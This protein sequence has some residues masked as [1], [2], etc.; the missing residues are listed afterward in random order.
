MSATIIE[1]C[2]KALGKTYET[3]LSQSF[4]SS[5]EPWKT[6]HD[7]DEF[8]L[9]IEDGL[10]L[11]FHETTRKLESIFITLVKT[12]PSTV[13]YKGELPKPFASK[14]RQTEV[15]T[16]FGESMTSKGPVKMPLPMGMTGGWDSY[17]LDP[18]THPNIKVVF[19]YTAELTVST[20]IFSLI[21]KGHD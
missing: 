8:S 20:L 21:D 15:R 18:I 2:I 13:V 16:N 6:F 5:A 17:R 14:M 7:D 9:K 11:T 1:D 4:I 10:S 3:L 12:T 19:H